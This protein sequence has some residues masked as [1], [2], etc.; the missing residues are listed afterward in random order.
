MTLTLSIIT[1]TQ[2]HS[3]I[4]PR[5]LKWAEP[6]IFYHL[7]FFWLEI[8]IHAQKQKELY[9]ELPCT[10]NLNFQLSRFNTFFIIFFFFTEVFGKKCQIYYNFTPT[11]FTIIYFR[12]LMLN[13]LG[14]FFK[15]LPCFVF[16][17]KLILLNSH[18]A[19]VELK[20]INL[21]NKYK[22]TWKNFRTQINW[23]EQIICYFSH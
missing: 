19:R 3:Y 11:Y 21:K 15:T 5:N 18:L 20:K 12:I 10:H 1:Y 14:S 7:P 23:I 17:K 9:N 22:N 13:L 4:I 6:S 2:M 8:F 16:K